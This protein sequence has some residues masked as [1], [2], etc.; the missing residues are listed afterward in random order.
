MWLP[1]KHPLSSLFCSG[2]FEIKWLYSP[3]WVSEHLHWCKATKE[4]LSELINLFECD[5]AWLV[6]SNVDGCM[7]SP[8]C[9]CCWGCAGQWQM[10]HVPGNQGGSCR[11][12]LKSVRQCGHS[13]TKWH[14]KIRVQIDWN[15]TLLC[16]GSTLHKYL[17]KKERIIRE[18]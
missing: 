8:L 12:L 1:K 18:I 16:Q 9:F 5:P 17:I 2:N 7:L 4:L 3:I 14:V 11:P 15:L 13:F 10:V 6:E